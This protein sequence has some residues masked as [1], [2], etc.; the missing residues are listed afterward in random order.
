M[1]IGG[2]LSGTP[3]RLL[4]SLLAVLEIITSDID[5]SSTSLMSR[6]TALY[7]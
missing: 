3:A 4:P 7:S 6:H 1:T 2:F 5:A